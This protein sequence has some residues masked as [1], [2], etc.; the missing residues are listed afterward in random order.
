MAKREINDVFRSERSIRSSGKSSAAEAYLD[1]MFDEMEDIALSRDEKL[2]RE[3]DAEDFTEDFPVGFRPFNDIWR[4]EPVDSRY[5]YK[6]MFGEPCTTKQQEAVDVICGV[7]PFEVTDLNWKEAILM[8]GKGAGKDS[9]IAKTFIYQGYKLA[10]LT[11]PQAFLGLGKGSPIDFVNVASNANQ[12]KNIFFKYLAA[13]LKG[14]RDP[15]TGLPWFATKNFYFDVGTRKFKYMDLRE[16]DGD[17][18]QREIDLQRGIKMHSLTSEKFTGEGLTIILAVMDEVGAMRSDRVFGVKTGKS[19]DKLVGQYDSLGTS[20]RRT[21]KFGKLMCISY[22]YG[23]NCPMSMLVK[24]S[25][26]NEKAFV[27]KYSTY[28][29]RTD[30]KEADLREQFRDDY[31]KDAEKAAMIYECKDPQYETTTLFSNQYII[32]NAIDETRKF[33]IN[34]FIGEATTINDIGKGI[35]QILQP[36]F[37]GD[38]EYYYAMHLDL[39]SGRT[40]NGD[41][42]IGIVMGH[43]QEMRVRY[44]KAW[45]DYY[46]KEYQVDLS[47]YQGQLRLGVVID[48]MAQLVCT[49]QQKE[50]RIADIRQFGID[51]QNK[52][53]FGLIKVTADRWQSLETI[54][55][56]NREGIESEAFSVDRS[57]APYY[58]MKDYMQQGIWRTYNHPVFLREAKEVLDIGN[59]IDHPDTSVER[60]ELEECEHGS[61]DV[62]DGCAAVTQILV[63]ELAENGEVFFG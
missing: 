34:P 31:E 8:W 21:S 35:D 30:K 19:D 15:D 32:R 10:C 18:K 29:V 26:K 43:M 6:K 17:I 23:S 5:F 4:Y 42:A 51:L 2:K 13:Y 37:R 28:E 41:D 33:T 24:R 11:N 48:L 52:R 63:Q 54:Q 40:W 7:D 59:K 50:V 58:T 53:G 61:K 38:P 12:A 45:I 14:V 22:K 36:W 62:L 56:F 47:E 57:K 27:R 20:V 9:S 39:A 3:H 49:K 25:A 60:F 44:D 1:T 16:R 46:M 55:E